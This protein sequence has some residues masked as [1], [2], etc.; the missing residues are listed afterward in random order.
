MSW[1][2]DSEDRGE[3]DTIRGCQFRVSP[4]ADHVRPLFSQVDETRVRQVGD[5]RDRY[6]AFRLAMGFI[7]RERTPTDPIKFQE[8]SLILLK[9]SRMCQAHWTPQEQRLGI[10]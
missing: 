8:I 10:V 4:D 5:R 6:R 2:G 3:N 1:K 7:H 9:L